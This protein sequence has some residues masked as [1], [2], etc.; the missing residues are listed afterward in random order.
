M[1]TFSC[2]LDVY[3]LDFACE[4]IPGYHSGINV[5]RGVHLQSDAESCVIKTYKVNLNGQS[6]Q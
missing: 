5:S 6:F 1:S 3:R 4:C 2:V